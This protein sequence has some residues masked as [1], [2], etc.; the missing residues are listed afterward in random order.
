MKNTSGTHP[1][2]SGTRIHTSVNDCMARRN[3]YF[4]LKF[5]AL[6]QTERHMIEYF[7]LEERGTKKGFRQLYS[8]LTNADIDAMLAST[9]EKLRASLA[10]FWIGSVRDV[11]L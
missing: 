6:S 9:L 10:E 4:A 11:L 3:I 7:V 8:E 2:A 5:A 1:G